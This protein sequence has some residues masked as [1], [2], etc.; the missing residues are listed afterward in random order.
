[1]A[2]VRSLAL[3]PAKRQPIAVPTTTWAAA[4][5]SVG[6]LAAVQPMRCTAAL[7]IIGPTTAAAGRRTARARAN[8]MTPQALRMAR[9]AGATSTSGSPTGGRAAGS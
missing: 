7:R 4:T 6:G 3:T 2:R 8:P 5:S 9:S 1:M